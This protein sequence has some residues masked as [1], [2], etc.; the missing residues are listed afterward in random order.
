[1]GLTTAIALVVGELIGIGIFLT[2]AEMAKGLGSP[3][4][5][6]AIWLVMAAVTLAGAL[7]LGELAARYPAAGGLY[8]Y[9]REAFGPGTAFLFGWM[10]MLVLDPG[11][12]A[13]LA[14]GLA[15]YAGYVFRLTENGQTICAVGAVLILA[16][17]NII[18][19]ALGAGVLRMLTLLKVGLLAVIICWGFASDRGGWSN[20]EPFVSRRP[21]SA[22]LVE[23]LA[24]GLIGAFFSF[25]GWW[26]IS[27][28]AG[29]V[30]DPGR[31]L[32]RALLFGILTVTIIY[33]LVSGVFLYLVPLD[34]IH[35]N[36]DAEKQAFVAH[37][38]E[39]IFGRAGGVFFSSVVIIA[40][41]GSL[42]C[43]MMGAPRVYYAMARDGLFFRG[44]AAVHPRFGSP[45]RA[46]LLQAIIAS[47]LVV[48]GKFGDILGYFM[49]AAVAF[50]ALAIAALPV[51]R[52][53]FPKPADYVTPAYP[54]TPILFLLSITIVLILLAMGS[55]K[56][57]AVG[58]G[59]VALGVPVYYLAFRKAV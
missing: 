21:D 7:C 28:M 35:L 19:V 59:V 10:S 18:G 33:V 37:V 12:A 31:T 39:V 17:I 26:D 9:L 6:F 22:P 41:L 2:P 34:S 13:A 24:G 23:A 47:I 56:Q 14:R 45:M 8:V 40:V 32:P 57:S 20:F 53:R 16:A 3:A 55:P 50:V 46:I 30:R 54:V 5:L 51:I 29:E 4:L 52:R 42:M 38:G 1:L 15:G 58:V 11:I 25:G 36:D 43:I 27:K 49:F 44:I 48:A